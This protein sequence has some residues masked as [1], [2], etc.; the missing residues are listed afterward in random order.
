MWIVWLERNRLS[1]ED[2]EK[3]LGELKDLCQRSLLEWSRCW[4][5]TDCSSITEFML[6][7]SLVS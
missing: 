2:I 7:L 6:S 3:T 5:F 4:G 1:F